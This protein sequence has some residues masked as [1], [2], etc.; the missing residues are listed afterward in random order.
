MQRVITEIMINDQVYDFIEE[1]FELFL[2]RYQIDIERLMKGS[3]LFLIM[4][5]NCS[6]NVIK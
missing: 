1:I 3:S 5:I 4:P 6:E 2:S